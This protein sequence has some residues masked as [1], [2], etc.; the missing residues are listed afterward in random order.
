M[1]PRQFLII[2]GSV[3]V[4]LAIVGYLG[5]FGEGSPLWLTPVFVPGLNRALEPFYRPIV[6]LVGALALFFTVFGFLVANVPPMNTFGVAHLNNPFDN[7]LHLVVGIWAV[8]VG[9]RKSEPAMAK[10]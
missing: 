9:L 1:N 4:L 7:I 6:L 8:Y 3:L 5:I 2:G 10:A